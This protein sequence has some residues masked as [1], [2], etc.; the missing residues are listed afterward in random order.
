M[1]ETRKVGLL[2][3]GIANPSGEPLAKR[4]REEAV[5]PK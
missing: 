2:G 1:Q 4:R 3:L 5:L